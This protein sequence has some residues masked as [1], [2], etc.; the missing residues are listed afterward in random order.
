METAVKAFSLTWETYMLSTT[1]YRAWTSMEAT[2]GNAILAKSRPTDMV[3]ILFSVCNVASIK[4]LPVK[5]L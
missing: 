3:P 2:I 5:I 1:L 4:F